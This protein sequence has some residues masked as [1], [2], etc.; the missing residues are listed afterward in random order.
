MQKQ[1]YKNHEIIL[2]D[3]ASTDDS[4]KYVEDLFP[5]VSIVKNKKNL[6]YAGGINSGVPKAKGK[7]LALLNTDIELDHRFLEELVH[8]AEIYPNAG[9]YAS[10]IMNYYKRKI[11]ENAGFQYTIYGTHVIRG[12]HE[13]DHGQY[14]YPCEVFYASGSAF[15]VRRDVIECVGGLD[16]K[17]FLYEEE[18]D[19]CWRARLMGYK[20]IFV[21]SSVVYHVRRGTTGR[22]IRGTR[23][24][25][26]SWRNKIRNLVKNN[27]VSTLLAVLPIRVL[28]DFSSVMFSSID[29]KNKKN[30]L[31]LIKAL[32]WNLQM[33]PDTLKERKAIQSRRCIS[34]K[35]VRKCM[36][37]YFPQIQQY[38]LSKIVKGMAGMEDEIRTPKTA[39]A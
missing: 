23:R 38:G 18:V 21:P 8:T 13:V 1:T 29:K 11:I 3:N 17:L 12:V 32:V 9:I 20:T 25:Y 31:S 14:D 6:G 10:K 22:F 34:P 24:D 5:H 27:D 33:F 15:F 19:F 4:V 36:Y 35:E 7:Y 37:S 30:V 16:Q 26:F 2:V 28:I 39:H